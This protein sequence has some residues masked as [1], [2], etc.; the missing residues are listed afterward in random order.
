MSVTRMHIDFA[1]D[2]NC[3]NILDS[4]GEICVRCGCCAKDKKVR[5]ESRIRCLERWL[6][7]QYEFDEWIDSCREL[8]ERNRRKNIQY[9]KR[10]LR[11]YRKKLDELTQQED[12]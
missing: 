5:Y 10:R 9:F 7:D 2:K 4:Y 8:Q 6:K 3:W 11:Y 1:C 12:C